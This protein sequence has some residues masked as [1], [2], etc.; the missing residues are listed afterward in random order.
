MFVGL[1]LFSANASSCPATPIKETTGTTIYNWSLGRFWPHVC[2]FNN[3][4]QKRPR[5]SILK[6]P[7]S[8]PQKKRQPCFFIKWLQHP[9]N[10]H[11][12][13]LRSGDLV[14]F[15][16][17]RKECP[18]KKQQTARKKNGLLFAR[19]IS[20]KKRRRRQIGSPPPGAA[21]QL[22]PSSTTLFKVFTLSPSYHPLKKNT[23][24]YI[25]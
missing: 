15:K 17:C 4:A 22:A 14:I 24:P 25:K 21:L 16:L 6:S 5:A 23:F 12:S 13:E 9:P 1:S 20:I 10:R 2:A 19:A 11:S 7:S 3:V 8:F 18:Q